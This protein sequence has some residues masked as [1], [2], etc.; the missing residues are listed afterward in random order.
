MTRGLPPPAFLILDRLRD[1]R[2]NAS[3][4]YNSV[5]FTQGNGQASLTYVSGS[6]TFKVGGSLIRA[7]SET[8]TQNNEG[9]ITYT[10]AGTVP[11]SITLYANPNISK[12]GVTQSAM[13]AQDQWTINNLTLNLGARLDLFN[14]WAPATHSP[15]GRWL[16]ARDY[17]AVED[18][19]D[20]KDVNLRLGTAYKLFGSDNTALK[21]SLGRF[22]P[23]AS[24]NSGTAPA[25]QV[26]LTAN[27]TWRDNGDY[28]PQEEELGPLS[29]ANFG[30]VVQN[31]SFADDVVRGWHVRPYN[32]QAAVSIEH[33]LRPGLGLNV[34]YYRTWYGNFTVTDNT[35]VGPSDY[36]SYCL[37]AP[38]DSRLPGGGGGQICGVMA[39]KP[40]LFGQVRNVVSRA[41]HFGDQ[42]ET[43]NGVDVTMS[44]RLAGGGFLAGGL[45]TSQ[46]VTDNCDVRAAGAGVGGRALRSD[47]LLPQRPIVVCGHAVQGQ[48]LISAALGLSRVGGLSERR[49][50]ADDR[51]LRRH[52]RASHAD[53]G[54]ASGR[55]SR[56]HRIGRVDRAEEPLPRWPRQ[57]AERVGRPLVPHR[58]A[59]RATHDRCVQRVQREFG[60]ADESPV[61]S[62]VAKCHE[63]PP[64]AHDQAAGRR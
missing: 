56:V 39:L 5:P 25:N 60:V 45:S 32:W 30:K 22:I 64:G 35:L 38:A 31:T 7:T 55:R 43:Y 21:A 11:E 50:R 1:F 8:I 2:Y 3:D 23:Y 61:W 36:D 6:H 24:S 28:I 20:W 37:P 44:M 53:T 47:P 42:T 13:Y 40:A 41:L 62:L 48:R 49:R 10:F 19:L 14:G 59:Q 46:T 52:E 34:G 18:T 26:V 12:N 51:N 58:R 29:N 63:H 9:S 4:N 54:A 15:A 33:E 27:R 17:P 16:P 57:H